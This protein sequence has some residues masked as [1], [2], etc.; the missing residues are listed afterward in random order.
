ME[1]LLLGAMPCSIV[2]FGGVQFLIGVTEGRPPSHHSHVPSSPPAAAVHCGPPG[3]RQKQGWSL[4][5]GGSGREILVAAAFGV[6]AA[7]GLGCSPV[8]IIPTPPLRSISATASRRQ[9]SEPSGSTSMKSVVRR[10]EAEPLLPLCF[11]ILSADNGAGPQRRC[12]CGVTADAASSS[13]SAR[14]GRLLQGSCCG[15][16]RACRHCEQWHDSIR[17]AIATGQ[18]LKAAIGCELHIRSRRRDLPGVVL[19]RF[20]WSLSIARIAGA[21]GLRFTRWGPAPGARDVDLS[22]LEAHILIRH[23][24]TSM[25]G[26]TFLRAAGT[27]AH[28]LPPARKAFLPIQSH[29][30]LIKCAANS[31]KS[32]EVNQE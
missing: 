31:S 17:A 14:G 29:F 19:D 3:R 13:M 30:A 9:A 28:R 1:R 12:C 15:T 11:A 7:G 16:T 24:Y 18:V 26:V 25:F 27:L 20:E 32:L 23:C 10:L 6:G 4:E 2:F 22:L 21:S 8:G 5:Q